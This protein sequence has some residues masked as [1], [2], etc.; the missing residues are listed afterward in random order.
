MHHP[1]KSYQQVQHQTTDQGGVL[2]LLYDGIIRE[3]RKAR[4]SLNEQNDS[5][6]LSL[7]KAQLGVV[8]LDRTLNFDADAKL[9][10]SLH[11]VYLHVLWVLSDVLEHKDP[12][13]LDG[14]ERLLSNLRDAWNQAA[15]ALRQSK[16]AV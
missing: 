3:I 9:A 7:L 10:E 13:P 6:A 5:G 8:E 15:V 4:M 16:R 1:A 14:A 12:A 2:L 11:Q